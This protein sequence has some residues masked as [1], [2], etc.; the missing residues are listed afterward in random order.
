[1]YNVAMVR[2]EYWVSTHLVEYQRFIGL[3]QG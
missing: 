1:M 3:A 2:H